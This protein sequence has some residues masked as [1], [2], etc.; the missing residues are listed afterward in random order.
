MSP[1]PS[2]EEALLVVDIDVSTAI[3]RRLVDARRQALASE[4]EIDPP[5]IDL[6][7]PREQQV[8]VKPYVAEPLDEL[9]QMRRAL[10]L[11]LSDYVEKTASAT[12]SSASPA[13]S[14]RR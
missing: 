14:T 10:E 5:V 4:R 3:A 2:F 13:G 7:G 12:S 9:E 11:G 1:A 6:G 8:P